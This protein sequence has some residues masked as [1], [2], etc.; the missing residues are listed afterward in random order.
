MILN[1]HLEEQGA[2]SG[3]GRPRVVS[4]FD[5]DRLAAF[6]ADRF[7]PARRSGSTGSAAGSRTRP[8]SSTGARAASS[9]ASSP[10]GRS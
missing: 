6:L 7:G 2:A 5:P 3:T 1:R 10:P 9:C 8:S 4:D